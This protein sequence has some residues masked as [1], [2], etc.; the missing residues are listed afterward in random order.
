MHRLSH[1][2]IF[3]SQTLP[4]QRILFMISM[5]TVDGY[6]LQVLSQAKH[7]PAFTQGSIQTAVLDLTCNEVCVYAC[8][9]AA[10][11]GFACDILLG[12]LLC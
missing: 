12:S 2:R 3:N 7:L 4:P 1:M 9:P 11:H 10:L 6:N 5:M 8:V